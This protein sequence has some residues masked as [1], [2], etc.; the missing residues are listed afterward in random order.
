MLP[1]RRLHHRGVVLR[2]HGGVGLPQAGGQR[3]GQH[4]QLHDHTVEQRVQRAGDLGA[5]G[6][7]KDWI[8]WIQ[9]FSIATLAVAEA[10]I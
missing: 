7:R 9:R 5:N 1:L 8:G 10:G 4:A 3:R 6:G 2:E